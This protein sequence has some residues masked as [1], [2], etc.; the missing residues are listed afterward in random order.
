[1]A[2]IR[3]DEASEAQT[4]VNRLLQAWGW[5]DA[6]EAGTTFERRIP[7]GSQA[8][9]TGKADAYVGNPPFLGGKHMRLNLGDGY[10]ERVFQRFPEVRDSV[11]FCTYWFRLAQENLKPDGRAGLVATNSIRHGKSRRASLD[12]IRDNGGHIHAAISTQPWSGEAN[13]H[14]SIVNWSLEAAGGFRLDGAEVATINTSLRSTVDV[15]EASALVANKGYCFQGVIPVGKGFN[16]EPE[17][18]AT[19]IAADPRNAEVVKP[20]SMGTNLAKRPLGQPDRW[21]IDFNDLTLEAAETFREPFQQV[22]DL[23]RPQRMGCRREATRVNWWRYGEKRPAMRAAIKPLDSYFAVPRVSKWAVF[24]PFRKDWLPGEKNVV[25]ASADLYMLAL[26]TSSVHRAWMHAQKGTLKGDIAYTH[27]SIFETFPF[28]QIVAPE[29]VQQIHRAMATL[30]DYR[31]E[32]MLARNC[33]ITDLYNA[34]FHEPASQLAKLHQALDALV[35][36]PY[37]WKASEDILSNLLDLN[38]ELAEREAAGEKVVGPW[39]PVG[40]PYRSA[41]EPDPASGPGPDRLADPA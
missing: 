5:A 19:W 2:T 20:F 1:M 37:G 16:V 7:K 31:N 8:G 10:V 34:Y 18:A 14:V 12:Y 28:P 33:G 23:V 41:P 3:G 27:D 21:I 15:S 22:K 36:K 40:S 11:D 24:I 17:T 32:V 29:L 25:L 30:N 39:A 6:V 35:L 26:L 4:Y 38:L 13:V 9:G